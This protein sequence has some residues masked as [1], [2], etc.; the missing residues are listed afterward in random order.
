VTVVVLVGVVQW[1]AQLHL[2]AYPGTH[3]GRFTVA[4]SLCSSSWLLLLEKGF[5]GLVASWVLASGEV[6]SS[7]EEL[8]SEESSFWLE[9]MD[10][11]SSR[12]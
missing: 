9:M 12:S 7:E 8:S 2:I 1:H 6:S 5:L 10:G 11:G 3:S 4:G